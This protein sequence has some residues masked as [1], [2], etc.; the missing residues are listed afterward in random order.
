MATAGF[1]GF[2]SRGACGVVADLEIRTPPFLLL[3]LEVLG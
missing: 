3:V 1:F 2:K